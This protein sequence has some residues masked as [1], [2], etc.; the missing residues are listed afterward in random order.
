MTTPR[1]TGPCGGG[2]R[3]PARRSGPGRGRRAALAIHRP[4]PPKLRR[5]PGRWRPASGFAIRPVVAHLADERAA[6]GA[7]SARS[8]GRRRGGRCSRRA[9]RSASIEVLRALRA[10]A[11]RGRASS[12]SRRT[13]VERVE[14][15]AEQPR[16]APAAAGAAVERRQQ[17]LGVAVGVARRSARRRC[18]WL[19]QASWTTPSSERRGVVRAQQAATP[20]PSAKATFSSASWSWHST[21]SAARG[22]PR[23]ARRRRGGAPRSAADELAPD[24]DDP[25]RVAADLDHV[26]EPA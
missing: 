25:R 13:S 16:A 5:Q 18:G 15:E 14:L 7:R 24:G 22:R 21:S 17:R 19:Q 12:T 23:S 6:V 8:R 3:R 11:R 20:A 26:R 9:R 10:P 2:P 1:P 4:R